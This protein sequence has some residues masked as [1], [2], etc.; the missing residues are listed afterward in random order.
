MTSLAPTAASLAKR[1]RTQ[2]LQ[3]SAEIATV[4]AEVLSATTAR[5]EGRDELAREVSNELHGLGFCNHCW[6]TRAL[7]KYG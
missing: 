5:G 4:S 2:F 1:I 7:R 6:M 3:G